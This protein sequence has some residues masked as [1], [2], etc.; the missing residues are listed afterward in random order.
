MCAGHAYGFTG[1]H[2][3]NEGAS[4]AMTGIGTRARE[5]GPVGH[6]KGSR[7]ISRRE[8]VSWTDGVMDTRHARAM[9]RAQRPQTTRES[10]LL[11]CCTPYRF[12]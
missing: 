6:R 5:A 9:A 12:H 1:Q 11:G 2:G 10:S 8:R 7:R 3:Q 4:A